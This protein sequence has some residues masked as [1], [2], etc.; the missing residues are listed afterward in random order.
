MYKT[1]KFLKLI[2]KKTGG[3]ISPLSPQKKRKFL[4]ATVVTPVWTVEDKLA[5]DEAMKLVFSSVTWTTVSYIFLPS[6]T[7][8]HLCQIPTPM[9]DTKC[10]LACLQNISESDTRTRN[11]HQHLHGVHVTLVF[12]Q[13]CAKR[14]NGIH[15]LDLVQDG[16][17]FKTEDTTGL[18]SGSWFSAPIPIES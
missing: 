10:N 1:R 15:L 11:G 4:K 14:W 13:K 3:G 2:Q 9:S 5:W 12:R 16:S 8:L 6:Q 18:T 17:W 7:I